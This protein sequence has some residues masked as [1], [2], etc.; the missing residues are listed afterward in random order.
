[1]ECSKL[2]GSGFGSVS[3]SLGLPQGILNGSQSVA[4]A[5][6]RAGAG[7][8]TQGQTRWSIPLSSQTPKSILLAALAR[9]ILAGEAT[10]EKIAAR[11]GRTLGREWRWL[12]TLA[13]R[14]VGRFE[15]Q[16]RPRR[17]D[18]V[19]FLRDDK[20]FQRAYREYFD[21]LWVAEWITEPQRM[22]PVAATREWNVPAIETA[23]ELADWLRIEPGELEWFADLKGLGCVRGSTRLKHYHY[24]VLTKKFGAIR[25]IEAP[26]QRLKEIQRRILTEILNRIPSHP[27]AHGFV[28]GRSIRTFAAPHV[29]RRVVVKMDLLDFFPS[30]S[31]ARVQSFFRTV[32]YPETVADFLGG[33]C[34]NAPPGEIWRELGPGTDPVQLREARSL[35]SR[36]HLPQGAPTSPALANICA[37]R[38]D[39]RL[40]ALGR[41]AG[42]AYTRYADDLAFSGDKTFERCAERFSAH[43]AAVLLEEGFTV[44]HRKTRIMRQGVRQ[45]LAGLV[46][47]QRVNVVRADFD[48][49]KAILNNCVRYGPESQN[50]EGHSSFQEHLRG[51]LEFVKMIHPEKGARL[52]GMFDQIRW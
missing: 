21:E 8:L 52:Q 38:V 42:A 43:V 35:Y 12:R 33:I 15:H 10:P 23:G 47:N 17:R 14:Y 48:R 2:T 34:T 18:V 7:L 36:P 40:S 29:G 6:L 28:K 31:G 4:R 5:S 45:R 44:H 9:S 37:Y 41:S 27:A 3:V 22:Q 19:R 51:R 24:R 39:C 13:R 50:R 16:V 32:G 11:C 26:K 25:L 1:V 46:A 20:G 30:L 49:F